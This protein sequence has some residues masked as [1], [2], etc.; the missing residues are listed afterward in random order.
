LAAGLRAGWPAWYRT[1]PPRTWLALPLVGTVCD[2]LENIGILSL[3]GGYPPF[4]ETAA[5]WTLL[6]K[7]AKLSVV[8]VI[9]CVTIGVF[10]LGTLRYGRRSWTQRR[11]ANES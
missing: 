10:L 6:A 2:W 11:K 1:T 8:S 3:L 5:A 4:N 7:Q 9:A